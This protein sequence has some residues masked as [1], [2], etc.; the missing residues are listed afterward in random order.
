[1]HVAGAGKDS[2]SQ[3]K[4]NATMGCPVLISVVFGNRQTA[5]DNARPCVGDYDA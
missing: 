2:V 3:R 1:M 5:L 4:E